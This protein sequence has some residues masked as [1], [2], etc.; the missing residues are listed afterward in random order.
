MTTAEILEMAS[1][2]VEVRKTPKSSGRE[3]AWWVIAHALENLVGEQVQLQES[4]EWKETLLEEMMSNTKVIVDAM[5]LFTWG[6]W[7]LRVQE[8]GKLE[9]TEEAELVVRRHRKRMGKGKGKEPERNPEVVPEVVLEG[10]PEVV[11]EASMDLEM[12]LQ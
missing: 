1:E 7:F 2:T 3:Q 11:P 5:D 10:V 9:G 8:M 6:E 12:T 4:T